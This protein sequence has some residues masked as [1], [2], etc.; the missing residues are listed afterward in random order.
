MCI[1]VA[2]VDACG[3]FKRFA[4]FLVLRQV[5]ARHAQIHISPIKIWIQVNR[6][7]ARRAGGFRTPQRIEYQ[8]LI[9][10][11]LGQLRIQAYGG[12]ATVQ[13]LLRLAQMPIG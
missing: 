3:F 7:L 1:R 13:R 4:C 5:V 10:V 2:G 9:A 11:R 12:R 6:L 8:T